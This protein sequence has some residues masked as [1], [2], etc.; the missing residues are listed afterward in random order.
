MSKFRTLGAIAL[1]AAS[2]ALAG[3]GTTGHVN[4]RDT[5]TGQPVDTRTTH[6]GTDGL[7]H[8]LRKLTGGT[9][10]VVTIDRKSACP[11]GRYNPSCAN[12]DR[13]HCIAA[14]DAY[15]TPTI[16]ETESSAVTGTGIYAAGIATGSVWANF[17]AKVLA[18]NVHFD[19]PVGAFQGIWAG[20]DRGSQNELYAIRTCM[21]GKGE[22][23]RYDI[24]SVNNVSAGSP[25]II[26]LRD[27]ATP[28]AY[29]DPSY[30]AQAAAP[31]V[32]AEGMDAE[33]VAAFNECK[34]QHQLRPQDPAFKAK[35]A[36]CWNEAFK[37][38][39]GESAHQAPPP[40]N[41]SNDM[42]P[43]WK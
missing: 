9:V 41:D 8:T 13:E 5:Q 43:G 11:Y 35:L 33:S 38:E 4:D 40:A 36:R 26:A 16:V 15:S 39:N 20:T 27:D 25:G 28:M 31:E 14:V 3:C 30:T 2:A 23:G 10:Q 7:G 37:I 24:V 42:P 1:L 6:F 17:G 21:S 22:V 34:R 18:T 12:I 19:T 32:D 29:N